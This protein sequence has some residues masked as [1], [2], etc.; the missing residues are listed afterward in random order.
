MY[1]L[2]H[3]FDS[4]PFLV[5]WVQHGPQ[6]LCSREDVNPSPPAL[7]STLHPGSPCAA[8]TPGPM[9]HRTLL[10]HYCREADSK[11]GAMDAMRARAP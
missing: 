10:L 9:L 4:W 1:A 3:N 7:G 11:Q 5:Q 8:V 6:P 2:P